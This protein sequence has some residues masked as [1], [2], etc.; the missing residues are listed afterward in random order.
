MKLTP[1]WGAPILPRADILQI[2]P[3]DFDYTK[4]AI[5]LNPLKTYAQ[6]LPLIEKGN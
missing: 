3:A 2:Q 4:Q 1:H 6:W 5:S